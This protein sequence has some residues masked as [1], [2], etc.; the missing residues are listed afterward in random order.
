MEIAERGLMED[1]PGDLARIAD[2]AGLEVALKL[3]QAFRGTYLYITGFDAIKRKL[4][5]E[6]IR[7]AYD[8]GEKV[9]VI[10]MRYELTERQVRRILAEAPIA[11]PDHIFEI[12]KI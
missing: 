4:R 9:K 10:C 2:I 3:G 1:L 6:S 5:D 8:S 11:V 12:I 7:R